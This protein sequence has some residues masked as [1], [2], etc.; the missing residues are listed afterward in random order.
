MCQSKK[1]KFHAQLGMNWAQEK[2]SLPWYHGY[3]VAKYQQADRE[4]WLLWNLPLFH[5][6][7]REIVGISAASHAILPN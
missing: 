3:V 1:P 6:Q 2:K 4:Y 7:G 5:A